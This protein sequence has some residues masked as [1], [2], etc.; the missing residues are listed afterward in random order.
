[1]RSL[2]FSDGCKMPL[3][4]LDQL[5]PVLKYPQGGTKVTGLL[6]DDP[7]DIWNTDP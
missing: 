7:M 6:V 2:F 1:M 4:Y 5:H 3:S